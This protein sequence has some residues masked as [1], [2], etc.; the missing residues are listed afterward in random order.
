MKGGLNVTPTVQDL[1]NQVKALESNIDDLNSRKSKLQNEI[2]DAI[3][4][5]RKA[6]EAEYQAKQSAFVKE[7]TEFD[8]YKKSTEE[9]LKNER[10]QNL[11]D[12]AES[13]SK[14]EAANK[15]LVSI[16]AQYEAISLSCKSKED[17]TKSGEDS[18]NERIKKFNEE[19]VELAR[20]FDLL[21]KREEKL[22]LAENNLTVKE[23]KLE[24]REELATNDLAKSNSVLNEAKKF[25]ES[26]EAKLQEVNRNLDECNNAKKDNKIILDEISKKVEENT[27]LLAKISDEKSVLENES[28]RVSLIKQQTDEQIKTSD[29]KLRLLVLEN[30]KI[31][32]KIATLNKLRA[33]A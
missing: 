27:A 5:E 20:G 14:V 10:E 24:K 4:K 9:A 28:K 13:Q 11:K 18:L 17:A 22:S 23:A 15:E 7:K 16:Q 31:D 33:G 30:R 12:C 19:T 26:T 25:N 3:S 8:E 2:D 21:R 6:L 29:E 32:E 1:A